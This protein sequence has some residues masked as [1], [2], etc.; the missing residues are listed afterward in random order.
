MADQY[1]FIQRMN[2][3]DHEI[4]WSALPP[5]YQEFLKALWQRGIIIEVW[6]V[7]SRSWQPMTQTDA[8][9]SGKKFY[10]LKGDVH[11]ACLKERVSGSKEQ[12][13]YIHDPKALPENTLCF[14]TE[15]RAVSASIIHYPK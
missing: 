12:F 8:I 13:V 7:V 15:G 4:C 3:H 11:Y 2:R 1:S 5:H 14:M 9:W 10:R 6:G